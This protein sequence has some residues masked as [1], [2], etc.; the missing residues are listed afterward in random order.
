MRGRLWR[1]SSLVIAF[2]VTA[3]ALGAVAFAGLQPADLS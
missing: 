2:V 3:L 1:R